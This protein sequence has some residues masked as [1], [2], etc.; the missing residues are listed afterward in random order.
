M[1]MVKGEKRTTTRKFYPGL[2][3]VRWILTDD[4]WHLIQ[5][6]PAVTGFVGGKNRPTTPMRDRRPRTSWP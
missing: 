5:S 4:S 3:L 1:E 6:I 2:R